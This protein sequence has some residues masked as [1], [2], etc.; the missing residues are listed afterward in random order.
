MRVG[1][2]GC[3]GIAQVHGLCIS[4]LN[5]VSI[6]CFCDIKI[7]RAKKMQDV[8]GGNVYD[9]LTS[10]LLNEQIDVLHICT[11]HYLHVPMALEALK[12]HIHVFM[13]KPPVIN[14]EEY[15]LLIEGSWDTYLGFC[16]QNRYNPSV[17]KVKEMIEEGITGKVLGVRGIVSWSRDES[18]YT[19]SDWRGNLSMEG[20]GVLINQTIHTLDLMHYFMNGRIKSVDAIMTN[21]HLKGVIDVEDT[22]SIYISYEEG[23]G[24][25]YGTNSYIESVP[26]LIELECENMRIRIEELNVTCY[27]KDGRTITLDII[28]KEGYGKD[29]WGAGHLDCIHDFYDCINNKKTFKQDLEGVKDTIFLMLDAYES[30]RNH[31]EVKYNDE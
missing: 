3:G 17:I 22:M 10:M 21:H 26:P 16:F 9:S 30:A 24:S 11:P 20:G 14:R 8:Y 15:K 4:K 29:Y 28:H 18:Y 19:N 31:I 2:V 7:E 25:F 27:Y 23:S 5:D 12:K 6:T 1:I 13:E